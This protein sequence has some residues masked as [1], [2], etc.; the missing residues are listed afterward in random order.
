MPEPEMPTQVFLQENLHLAV[1]G[2]DAATLVL[3]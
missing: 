1:P 2:K 3:L